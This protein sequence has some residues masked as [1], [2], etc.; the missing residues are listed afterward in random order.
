MEHDNRIKVSYVEKV[1]LTNS[2]N[3][4]HFTGCSPYNRCVAIVYIVSAYFCL[5]FDKHLPPFSTL[6]IVLACMLNRMNLRSIEYE[7][8][9][10]KQNAYGFNSYEYCRNGLQ[11]IRWIGSVHSCAKVI[12]SPSCR[13]CVECV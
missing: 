10:F 8:S 11:S 3:H 5:L 7:F 4:S 13:V 12:Q 2:K 1:I 6:C 9:S